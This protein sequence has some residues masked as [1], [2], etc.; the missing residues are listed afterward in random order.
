MCSQ[1]WGKFS[2]AFRLG[3]Q[4]LVGDGLKAEST[5]ISGALTRKGWGREPS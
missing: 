3:F 5:T 4:C 1:E 2:A